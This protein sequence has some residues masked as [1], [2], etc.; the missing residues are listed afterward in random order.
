MFTAN[1]KNTQDSKS[2]ICTRLAIISTSREAYCD[3]DYFILAAASLNTG[4]EKYIFTNETNAKE[5]L[6]RLGTTWCI[7]QVLIPKT[8]LLRLEG[9][10]LSVKSSYI[11][12]EQDIQAIYFHPLFP[13]EHIIK[14][15]LLSAQ[16][17]R[18]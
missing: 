10:R 11:F 14:D 13:H 2:Y 15:S 3:P 17:K 9:E 16:I 5:T 4:E 6:K 8:Q 12:K 1:E 18:I 7:Y